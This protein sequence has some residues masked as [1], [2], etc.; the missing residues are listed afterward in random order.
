M[1]IK[2]FRDAYSIRELKKTYV[3]KSLVSRLKV[4][5]FRFKTLRIEGFNSIKHSAEYPVV[6]LTAKTNSDFVKFDAHVVDTLPN[7]IFMPGRNALTNKLIIDGINLAD[8]SKG[9]E[10]QNLE[11]IV[12]ID[13]MFKF[14]LAQSVSD[15]MYILPS[16]LWNLVAGTIPYANGSDTSITTVLRISS[17]ED[18]DLSMDN[19]LKKCWDLETIGI[20]MRNDSHISND[21]TFRDFN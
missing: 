11:I 10:C 4:D 20:N 9:D 15:S 5:P 7:K 13:N 1:V 18:E 2:L 6:Q 12:G 19:M 14:M 3:L 17:N 21:E 16:K 8:I